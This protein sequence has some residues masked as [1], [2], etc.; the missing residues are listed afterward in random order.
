MV[1]L[2]GFHVGFFQFSVLCIWNRTFPHPPPPFPPNPEGTLLPPSQTSSSFSKREIPRCTRAQSLEKELGEK[3][4][5]PTNL[6]TKTP[7]HTTQ[8]NRRATKCVQ[9]SRKRSNGAGNYEFT[10]ANFSFGTWLCPAGLYQHFQ[11]CN[12]LLA[13]QWHSPELQLSPAQAGTTD[14]RSLYMMAEGEFGPTQLLF[15][16]IIWG[17]ICFWL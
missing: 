9:T 15:A 1:L 2:K 10:S 4:P 8:K 12:S 17:K 3:K 13:L 14:W 6:T 11:G 5:K 16:M 7:P